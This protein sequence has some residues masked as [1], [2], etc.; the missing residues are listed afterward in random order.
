MKADSR[1]YLFAS[2]ILSAFFGF[3]LPVI[4][5]RKFSGDS[6]ELFLFLAV[7]NPIIMFLSFD[8]RKHVLVGSTV[9]V[10]KE[11][12]LRLYSTIIW[13][14]IALIASL[15]T[16]VWV[17][18]SL[19]LVKVFIAISELRLSFLQRS[20]SYRSVLIYRIFEGVI[21]FALWFK[22]S[23]VILL[24]F[25]LTS[26]VVNLPIKD[27]FSVKENIKSVSNKIWLG[28]QSA[29]VSVLTYIPVYVITL[30]NEPSI[31]VSEYSVQAGLMSGF[32]MLSSLHLSIYSDRLRELSIHEVYKFAIKLS[33]FYLGILVVGS[34]I[35][36]KLNLFYLIYHENVQYS[37]FFIFVS[38]VVFLNILK[39]VVYTIGFRRGKAER[40]AKYRVMII[41]ISALTVLLSQFIGVY[42]LIFIPSMSVIEFSI[43]IRELR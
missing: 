10:D 15:Y 4:V 37:A 43:L 27:I 9:G 40:M 17:I 22:P 5:S 14:S 18:L 39:N 33:L 21:I 38:S 11:W 24:F 1:F 28:F 42:A 34:V 6:D 7:L 12:S 29:G 23:L 2:G 41:G 16:G 3:M 30:I 13:L 36:F 20:G 8:Q 31:S 26:V 32:Y 25:V 35:I 19:S